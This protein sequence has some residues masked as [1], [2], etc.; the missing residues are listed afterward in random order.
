LGRLG[1][2]E[3]AVH[4]AVPHDRLAELGDRIDGVRAAVEEPRDGAVRERLDE[5]AARVDELRDALGRVERALTEDDRRDRAARL[6]DLAAQLRDAIADPP[7]TEALTRLVSQSHNALAERLEGIEA[8]VA[9]LPAVPAA[10]PSP[11]EPVVVPTP[12][13]VPVA[14]E[15]AGPTSYVAVVPS[16]DGYA[17]VDLNGLL[18]EAGST[19]DLE[20]AGRPFTVARVGRSPLPGDRRRCAFLEA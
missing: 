2:V 6:D 20:E 19:L 8:T 5:Q 1:G 18:P 14:L 10:P 9:G 17:L 3:S 11:P 13:P 12:E 15:P 7:G 16:A 4:A